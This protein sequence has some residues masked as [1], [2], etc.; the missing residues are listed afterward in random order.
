MGDI[1]MVKTK[2]KDDDE[3][4]DRRQK[5]ADEIFCK[6]CGVIIKKEAE[7]CPKCGVRQKGRESDSSHAYPRK[8]KSRVTAAIL[9]ILLGGLGIH[10]FYIGR[11]GMGILYIIF[12]WTFIPAIV[13]LIEGI[14]YLVSTDTDEEFSAKYVY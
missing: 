13:G 2:E 3:S 11:P 8:I 14:I 1:K 6:S 4:Y 10:K 7:I 9:A 12:C 5:G